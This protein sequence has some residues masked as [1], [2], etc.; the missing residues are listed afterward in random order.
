MYQETATAGREVNPGD[1]TIKTIHTT[2]NN[3][4]RVPTIFGI[5]GRSDHY[6]IDTV[7]VDVTCVR[8]GPSGIVV[9][10]LNF[11][12]AFAN[13]DIIEIDYGWERHD[14]SRAFVGPCLWAEAAVG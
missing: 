10:A 13:G 5:Y 4:C 11:E 6:V 3:I 1:R 7:T 9:N 12:A 2:E 8:H 14:L